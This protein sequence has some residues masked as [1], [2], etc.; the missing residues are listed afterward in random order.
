MSDSSL[1][2]SHWLLRAGFCRLFGRDLL[3]RMIHPLVSL[4]GGW[5][6]GLLVYAKYIYEAGALPTTPYLC[7]CL[8]AFKKSTFL[9]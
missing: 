8:V 4:A 7:W 9:W 3:L 1:V 5:M 2:E 6:S